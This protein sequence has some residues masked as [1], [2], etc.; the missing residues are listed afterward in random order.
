[1]INQ[2]QLSLQSFS[3]RWD[4]GREGIITENNPAGY[5]FLLGDLIP[6]NFFK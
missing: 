6:M 2:N 3:K 1:M 5:F 4:T